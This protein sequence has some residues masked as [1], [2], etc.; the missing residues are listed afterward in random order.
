MKQI[1]I[2]YYFKGERGFMGLTGERGN[3]GV[4]GREGPRGPPGFGNINGTI[5][6]PPGPIG[7]DGR[8]VSI[9]FIIIYNIYV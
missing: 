1:L 7:P 2:F 6:G 8:E 9:Y 5:V 3:A 4:P